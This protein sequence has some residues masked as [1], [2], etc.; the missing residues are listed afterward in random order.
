[1]SYRVKNRNLE[2]GALGKALLQPR[3][4]WLTV[5]W[6][7]SRNSLQMCRGKIEQDA[8]RLPKVAQT[9]DE[10]IDGL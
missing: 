5:K 2:K 9:L 4:S 10:L 6:N 7:T 1:M 8:V 3:M